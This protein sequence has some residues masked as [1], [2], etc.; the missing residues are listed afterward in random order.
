M[1]QEHEE[2]GHREDGYASN[3]QSNSKSKDKIRL[4]SL[5]KFERSLIKFRYW[6]VWDNVQPPRSRHCEMWNKWILK[7]D[8]HCFYIANWVGYH[9]HKYFVLLIFYT[10]LACI[11]DSLCF[12]YGWSQGWF[13]SP[14]KSLF[15]L[16]NCFIQL[17]I[18]MT[19]S[20]L[21]LLLML[22]S[23]MMIKNT[24]VAEVKKFYEIICSNSVFNIGIINNIKMVMGENPWRWLLPDAK[25][26]RKWNGIDF[27]LRNS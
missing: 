18:F 6:Q 2:N 13:D 26:E 5:S 17:S 25:I 16:A 11:F 14:V 22:T 19:M 8:H 9:N 1:E 3:L 12:V 24:S 4:L 20:S 7:Y 10:T 27:P 21:I 15:S 23:V